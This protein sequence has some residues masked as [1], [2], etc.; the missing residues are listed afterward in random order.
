M[1][2]PDLLR[3]VITT[4]GLTDKEK[5]DI[6]LD[7]YEFLY[8]LSLE[9]QRLILAQYKNAIEDQAKLFNS[10]LADVINDATIIEN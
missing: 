10:Y 6:L 9:S 2:S 3:K 1:K 4:E 8:N 5:I 7:E